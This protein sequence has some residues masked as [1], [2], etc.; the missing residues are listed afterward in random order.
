MTQNALMAI[1]MLIETIS[2]LRNR[3]YPVFVFSM[4]ADRSA[5]FF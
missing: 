5:L 4:T 3:D 1:D 2:D